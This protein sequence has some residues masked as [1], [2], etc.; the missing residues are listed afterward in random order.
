[1]RLE[2]EDTGE[3]AYPVEEGNAGFRQVGHGTHLTTSHA[4]SLSRLDLQRRTLSADFSPAFS[5]A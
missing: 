5:S 1:V 2:H 3:A 4:S